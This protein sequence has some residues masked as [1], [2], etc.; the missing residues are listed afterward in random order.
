MRRLNFIYDRFRIIAPLL[1]LLGLSYAFNLTLGDY[2]AFLDDAWARM[3]V[4]RIGWA[5]FCVVAAWSFFDYWRHRHYVLGVVTTDITV[6]I[7]DNLRDGLLVKKQEIVAYRDDVTGYYRTVFAGGK[8]MIQKDNI[9]FD[10]S[11][12][13]HSAQSLH[14]EGT[15]SQWDVAHRFEP[16]PWN[17]IRPIK[18]KRTEQVLYE[19]I[20]GDP[21]DSFSI[22]VPVD[23]LHGPIVATIWFQA[24]ADPG[25]T[26]CRAFRVRAE[27]MTELKL[28]RVPQRSLSSGSGISLNISKPK[29]KDKFLIFWR[30][31][32]QSVFG[33]SPK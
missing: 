25:L 7:G 14:I 12:C 11:H 29:P 20:F 13:S 3:S 26:G 31:P 2:A 22:D 23:Y 4:A 24:A 1:S 9:K 10:I 21:E 15:P 27:G 18:V 5:A 17:P 8:G 30:Y 16:I 33:S 6:T 19:D 32:D 28:Q